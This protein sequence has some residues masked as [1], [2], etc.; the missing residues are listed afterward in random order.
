MKA[1]FNWIT[2]LIDKYHSS[3]VVSF[4]GIINHAAS[5]NGY[6]L[7][8]VD[9]IRRNYKSGSKAYAFLV[10]ET[11][12]YS[13]IWIANTTLDKNDFMVVSGTY[14]HGKHHQRHSCYV[15]PQSELKT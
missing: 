6:K 10:G 12:E 3:S 1:L 9:N 4:N 13:A 11:T 8:K 14:G 7:V 2:G 5:R 15:V